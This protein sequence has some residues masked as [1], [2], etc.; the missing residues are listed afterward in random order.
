MTLGDGMLSYTLAANGVSAIDNL[1]S[2][3]TFTIGANSGLEID[4]SA[5]TGGEG[6]IELVRRYTTISGTFDT[7]NVSITGLAE[8]LSGE[9][10]YD[11]TGVYL[12]VIPEP[13][14]IG[15]VGLVSI[16]T[17]FIRRRLQMG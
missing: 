9:I 11:A 16:G 14:T 15:M 13:A 1:A 2:G 6:T 8:G 12:N 5:Y 10:T 17:L 4:A 7:N 3:G